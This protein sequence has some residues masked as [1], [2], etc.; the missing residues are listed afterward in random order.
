MGWGLGLCAFL[1]Q[2]ISMYAFTCTD[3]HVRAC[4][5]VCA[6]VRACVREC[7]RVC[8]CVCVCVCLCVCV[9]VCVSVSVSVSV[10]PSVRTSV[11]SFVRPSV[12]LFLCVSV[13]IYLCK[14]E[15]VYVCVV[16]VTLKEWS[17]IT[18]TLHVWSIF[19][20]DAISQSDPFSLHFFKNLS[21]KKYNEYVAEI[22][23]VG[24]FVKGLNI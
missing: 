17:N 15:Y 8:V 11:C 14:C 24:H 16:R 10:Y 9:C 1:C 13:C 23:C 18:P 19:H 2:Y 12:R 3:W 20:F 6:C 21:S 22:R 7:V 4:V 5:C